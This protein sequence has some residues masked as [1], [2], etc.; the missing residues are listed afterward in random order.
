MLL[1]NQNNVLPLSRKLGTIAV[2]G[3]NAD[4]SKTL[5]GNYNGI[6]TAPVT[7]LEGIKSK[8]PGTKVIYARGSDVALNMPHF[9]V[10]PAVRTPGRNEG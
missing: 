9:E 4:D 8:V 2:I 3:P 1:K 7:P 5:L 10:I 6:P